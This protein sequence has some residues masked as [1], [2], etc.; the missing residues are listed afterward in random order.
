MNPLEANRPA[1]GPRSTRRGHVESW[2]IKLN[3]PDGSRALWLK[4]TLFADGRSPPRAESWAIAF[5][6][7]RPPRGG[8]RSAPLESHDTRAEPFTLAFDS[9]R[10]DGDHTQGQVTTASVDIVWSFELSPRVPMLAPFPY[11]WMYRARF[12]EFKLVSPVPDALARGSYTIDGERVDV[13]G[14]RVMQGHNWGVRHTHRYAWCQAAGFDEA[15]DV[16][17]EGFSGRLRKA[18]ME[19]PWLSL[20]ALW[21]EGAWLRFDAPSSIVG[22]HAEASVMRWVATFVRPDTTLHVEATAEPAEAA[23]LLYANPDAPITHCLNSKLATLRLKLSDRS[24]E[25]VFHTRRAA[26]ELGWPSTD[27]GVTVVA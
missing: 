19:L 8:K 9:N 1:F 5:E 4:W 2:F 12:P 22:T 23:A 18:R 24:G 11:E 17:F 6:R 13:S 27:H 26:L 16:V 14:W 15:D 10:F 21:I 20:A 3:K 7:G 25:R